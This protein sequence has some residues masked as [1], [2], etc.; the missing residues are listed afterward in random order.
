M[1]KF[2]SVKNILMTLALV[3]LAT[4][5]MGAATAKAEDPTPTPAAGF[6]VSYDAAKD[7]LTAT[8]GGYI[9]VM[10]SAESATIKAK[11]TPL[12]ISASSKVSLVTK[13]K[14]KEGNSA[15]FYISETKLTED[16]SVEPNLVV[17]AP[18]Y[19]KI[20]VS[21][22]YYATALG[23]ALNSV[24]GTPKE[25][26]PENIV[27]A[28]TAHDT[29]PQA[30]LEY[31]TDGKTWV[32]TN[33]GTA[34]LNGKKLESFY[35]KTLYLRVAGADGKNGDAKRASKALK[36]KIG[37]QATLKAVKVDV[38]KGTIALK[39]G[40]DYRV[41]T[42]T[43]VPST[44]KPVEAV[45]GSS[46][47]WNTI[48]PYNKNGKQDKL[49][50]SIVATAD[51]VACSPKIEDNLGYFTTL[52]LKSLNITDLKDA[53]DKSWSDEN[54]L[55]V[56]A[57]T[58]ATEKKPCSTSVAVLI[59][60]QAAAPAVSLGKDKEGTAI[61][62]VTS[63]AIDFNAPEIKNDDAD[64]AAAKYEMLVVDAADLSKVDLYASKF[65]SVK[66]KATK[67]IKEG[68]KYKWV[69]TDG[70]T[71]EVQVA[72]NCI[73]L[74]RRAADKKSGNLA[75]DYVAYK[76]TKSGDTYTFKKNE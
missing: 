5:A 2:M 13:A 58:S 14:V 69:D 55:I 30:G 57:R 62:S 38:A 3:I 49:A 59:P 50:N 23:S 43:A 44:I 46:V 53:S 70:E 9:Y 54:S 27:C 29:V 20:E 63:A 67:A 17:P 41:L 42:S 61:T 51:F 74:I 4:L 28:K 47:A 24:I 8:T 52:K 7:E 35:G 71:H 73:I 36:V 18:S 12:S 40:M 1:K 65:K 64:K 26:D 48:L 37:K 60:R 16:T 6:E 19:K 75:S 39:N 68:A 72:E 15:Y 66:S 21:I 31:S 22:D 45:S 33:D 11:T 34:P 56:E 32:K 25:G 76:V 10:K